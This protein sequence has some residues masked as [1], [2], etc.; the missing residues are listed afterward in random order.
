MP[1]SLNNWH[2][3]LDRQDVAKYAVQIR[4]FNFWCQ[5]IQICHV[6]FVKITWWRNGRCCLHNLGRCEPCTTYLGRESRSNTSIVKSPSIHQHPVQDGWMQFR[7]AWSA[8][9]QADQGRRHEPMP[10][11]QQHARNFESSKAACVR[12]PVMSTPGLQYL[13]RILEGEYYIFPST[14]VRIRVIY[15]PKTEFYARVPDMTTE[16]LKARLCPAGQELF[17]W[18][19]RS[20]ARRGRERR[21]GSARSVVRELDRDDRDERLGEYTEKA[22]LIWKVK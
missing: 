21:L 17:L 3:L 15:P 10:H 13:P 11:A 16:D 7:R 14:S 22:L 9:T 18:W 6:P 20:G 5:S 12:I 1:L 2:L 8:G 4:D 19:R